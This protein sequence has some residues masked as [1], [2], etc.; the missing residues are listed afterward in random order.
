MHRDDDRRA[1]LGIDRVAAGGADHGALGTALFHPRSA[2]AAV[3]LAG[4][5][6]VE[7][8]ARS[9]RKDARPAREAA[10]LPG[11]QRFPALARRSLALGQIVGS[12][13]NGK[14]ILQLLAQ[15]RKIRHARQIDLVVRRLTI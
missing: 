15:R 1:D 4:I 3:V 14:Q 5:P 7:A 8:L 13:V 6:A 10:E 2:A 12:L 9:R 11:R